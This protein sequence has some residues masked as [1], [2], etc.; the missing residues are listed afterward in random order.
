[1]R[2]PTRLIGKAD[3]DEGATR[4]LGA[5]L[6][7]R[8]ENAA[9]RDLAEGTDL[10]AREFDELLVELDRHPL[11]RPREVE[12]AG[13]APMAVP[14]KKEALRAELDALG[15]PGAL[16]NVR[17]LP[18]FVVYGCGRITLGLDQIDLRSHPLLWSGEPDRPRDSGDSR[19][20]SGRRFEGAV[21]FI[22]SPVP[23]LPVLGEDILRKLALGPH[24][25]S[26]P[27]TIGVLVEHTDRD[28]IGGPELALQPRWNRR[29]AGFRG[30]FPVRIGGCHCLS[31]FT[32]S[33]PR[34][35]R[36]RSDFRSPSTRDLPPLLKTSVG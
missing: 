2:E 21:L 7:W 35:D 24:H 30:T 32:C 36:D 9:R 12:D 33:Q 29:W 19:I 16:G 8:R 26:Q 27:R 1:M 34:R 17:L 6:E 20:E 13:V 11:V 18:P 25:I 4:T 14:A 15:L 31:R 22:D 23:I 5:V 10:L 28:G 3:R